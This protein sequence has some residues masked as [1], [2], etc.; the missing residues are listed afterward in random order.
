VDEVELNRH[1]VASDTGQ[2]GYDDDAA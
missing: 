1:V 2:L